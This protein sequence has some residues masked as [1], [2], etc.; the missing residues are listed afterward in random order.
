MKLLVLS[1]V[2]LTLSS[3]SVGQNSP[4]E[5]GEWFKLRVTEEGIY[6]IDRNFLTQVLGISTSGLDPRTIKIYGNAQKGTL[7]QL[8]ANSS[9]PQLIE[10]PVN[11]LGFEDG[12]FDAGDYL[13]FYGIGPDNFQLNP[14]GWIVDQNI[15]SRENFYFLT[16]GGNAAKKITV[17]D[18]Q[19]A[20]GEIIDS[21]Y[22][23][24][25]HEI[26]DPSRNINRS[27]RTWYGEFMSRSGGLQVN[28]SLPTEGL[29]DTLKVRVK[30]MA[31]TDQNSNFLIS[32]NDVQI[33]Q[34][35][36]SRVATNQPYA[37]KGNDV[38][39][40]FTAFSNTTSNKVSV[41]L[42]D[43]GAGDL[44]GYLDFITLS[45]RKKIEIIN[46]PIFFS[47]PAQNSIRSIVVKSGLSNEQIWDVSIPFNPRVLS[48]SKI[49]NEL[50]YSLDLASERRFAAFIPNHASNPAFAGKMANQG[51]LTLN[52]ADGLI[53]TNPLFLNQA[54]RLAAFRKI[55]DGLDVAVVTTEEIY[56][57]FSSG[58]PDLTALRDATRFYWSKNSS[59]RYLLLFGD[60]SYDYLNLLPNNTNFVP[61]YQSRN[62]LDPVL[63]HS[64]DDFFGFMDL[65]EGEWTE[66]ASGDHT[67]EIG[68]GRLPVKSIE[69]ARNVVDK[70][71]RYENNEFTSG[72]WKNSITY[73]AD[74]GDANIHIRDAEDLANYLGRRN[75]FLRLN[76]LYIDAF[77][78]EEITANFSTSETTRKK[79]IGA[80]NEGTFIVN[81]LGHGSEQQLAA[82][83]IFNLNDIAQLSNRFKLPMFLTA[84]CEFGRYDDPYNRFFNTES[85]AEKLLLNPNGGAIALLTTTRPVYAFSNFLVNAAFHSFVLEKENGEYPRLGDLMRNTKNYSLAGP[86]NRNF[87]LLGD[88]MMRLAYPGENATLERINGKTIVENEPD[89][90][91]ALDL[92]TLDGTIRN[93]NNEIVE[94]FE[95]TVVLT[96]FDR[97]TTRRTNGHQSS[98]YDFTVQENQIFNGQVSVSAGRFSAEFPIPKNISYRY[99]SGKIVLFAT[100]NDIKND[101]TGAYNN[102]KIGGSNP[103]S[104]TETEPPTVTLYLNEP[105]FKS[106]GKVGSSSLLFVRV[107]DQSGINTTGLGVGQN[108][109]MSIDGG[110]P[111]VINNYYQSDLDTYQS[112]LFTIPVNDLSPGKHRIA[113]KIWDI[114]NNSTDASVELL[115]S[116]EP[117]LQLFNVMNYPNPASNYTN[118]QFEHDRIGNELTIEA[119]IYTNVGE[120]ISRHTFET[121]NSSRTIRGLEIE[122]PD[123]KYKPGIYF[124]KIV[125]TSNLDKAKGE[126]INRLIIIN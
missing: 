75:P 42:S 102:L 6:K 109:T 17:V 84:T 94:S 126:S 63:S 39:G 87:A 12:T 40:S 46:A 14:S 49:N 82:E 103:N 33:G 78:K 115:V 121:G 97:Q 122:L 85:G 32:V 99:E 20:S 23:F 76:K 45:F 34:I 83:T 118:I 119:M 35:S 29:I 89:T 1:L 66:N 81:Y 26:N 104:L 100:S 30:A 106:G 5:N 41:R 62:S 77:P 69:E 53:I 58:V 123:G 98:P 22:D 43:N 31:Q 19:N 72:D 108:N 67:L 9:G 125:V 7:P 80:I 112:G 54:N 64:S 27:G 120:L 73:V 57:D 88:P 36:V 60:C 95:G 92:I 51:I 8:N 55:N 110:D 116:D 48:V 71:I 90:L 105:N 24:I 68:I 4:L 113:V 117:Q 61:V 25:H 44:I 47:V 11:T 96:V 114:H 91:R 79:L 15:Y 52:P 16:Y 86:V 56:N 38:S 124:C 107:S 65:D 59:F 28:V 37:V 101:A 93:F 18:S 13:L 111:I 74:D 21:Y 70:L 3:Q 10:N 2:L 50:N